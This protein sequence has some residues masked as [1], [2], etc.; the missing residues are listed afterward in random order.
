MDGILRGE[1]RVADATLEVAA[2][3]IGRGTEDVAARMQCPQPVERRLQ[4]VRQRVVCGIHAGEQGVAAGR[5]HLAGVKHRTHRG[6][7]S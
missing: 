2:P 1:L 3:G 5:R 6:D 4:P 7:K